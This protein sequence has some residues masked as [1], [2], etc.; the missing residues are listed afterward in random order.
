[1]K[2]SIAIILADY[3]LGVLANT[4]SMARCLAK[5]GFMVDIFIDK[6]MYESAKIDFNDKNIR[7]ITIAMDFKRTEGFLA[8]RIFNFSVGGILNIFVKKLI[9][10]KNT[11]FQRYSGHIKKPKTF[12][13]K[14]FYSQKYFF[15]DN[16][17]FTKCLS[18]YIDENY[19]CLIGAEPQ[20]LIPATIISMDKNIPV[21]YHNM[22]LLLEKECDTKLRKILKELE[23]ECN[24]RC[25]FTIIQDKN[26][27]RYL[28]ED[29]Q[30]D[31][32][33][34]KLLPDSLLDA[35]NRE[36]SDYL[37]K[38]LDIEKSKKI[39][40]YAGNLSSPISMSLEIAKAAQKWDNQYV[41]VLHTWAKLSPRDKYSN[42]LKK[43][44]DNKKIYLSTEYLPAWQL[45]ELIASAKIGLLFYQKL[46][47]TSYE[48]G[49]ASNKLIRYLQSGLPVV[50]IDFPSLKEKIVENK[51]GICVGNPDLIGAALPKIFADYENY[52]N[53]AYKLY[54]K[55]YDFSKN[56]RDILNILKNE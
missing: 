31:P 29:N 16:F 4:T 54:E 21:I 27:A 6:Y 3:P 22:E 37:Y 11:P 46:R 39:I 40:L 10:F 34:V 42:E 43:A 14:L 30:L 25:L 52:S 53:N 35:P 17:K 23:R 50:S 48:L 32:Q 9:N 26:R 45:P 13:E 55:D 12:K 20:G 51:C 33:K 47:I 18:K 28:I 8:K 44:I 38:K 2:K 24:Q 5:E 41:L 15:P 56:F 19:L 7:V 36:K 1:M 49:S